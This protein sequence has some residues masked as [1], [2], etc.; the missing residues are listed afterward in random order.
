M[1]NT[2]NALLDFR[3]A[4]LRAV[5]HSWQDSEYKKNMLKAE[6]LLDFLESSKLPNLF[7]CN[8]WPLLTIQISES[9]TLDWQPLLRQGWIGPNDYIEF[10][11]PDRPSVTDDELAEALTAY[12]FWFPSIL[13]RQSTSHDPL[14]IRE[15]AR[16]NGSGQDYDIGIGGTTFENM[17]AFMLNVVELSWSN[18]V[19]KDELL[20]ADD[21]ASGILSKYFGVNNP[22][23]FNMKFRKDNDGVF[24]YIAKE[25]KWIVD[26]DKQPVVVHIWY[27]QKPEE[28]AQRSMAIAAYNTNGAEYPFSCS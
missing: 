28:T 27:P 4:Y 19:F 10:T 22:L 15:D 5:A 1:S 13:G 20:A 3:V 2:T 7:Y 18:D 26:E 8:P 24:K 6:N 21:D 16:R 12:Y 25:Q 17:A 9:Q 14:S 23:N 11:L